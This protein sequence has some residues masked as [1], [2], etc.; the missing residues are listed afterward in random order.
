MLIVSVQGLKSE[1][2][3]D[4]IHECIRAGADMIRTDKPVYCRVPLIGL[5]K[6]KV[7]DRSKE[8]YITPD[9][10]HVKRVS[11]WAM[12]IAVDCRVEN[13]N[14]DEIFSYCNQNNIKIV[15][16]L[17]K[18]DDYLALKEKGHFAHYYTTALGVFSTSGIPPY[19]LMDQLIKE[20]CQN[21]VAEGNIN[22]ENRI[23]IISDKGIK[24]ICIGDAI[25][26]PYKLTKGFNNAIMKNRR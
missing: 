2:N 4:I 8:P 6:V 22:S 15:A 24:S 7:K 19:D 1:T 21:I 18:I 10:E 25:S 16:D 14:L 3:T 5:N 9:L 23:K 12:Y 13:K 26:N 11:K 20:G 17:Q